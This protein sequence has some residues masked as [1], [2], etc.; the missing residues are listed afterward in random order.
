MIHPDGTN[1]YRLVGGAEYPS[2]SP[3]GKRIAY[4]D[5]ATRDLA[6]I[7]ADGTHKH[8]IA[9][10]DAYDG[11]PSFSPAGHRIAF[12]SQRGFKRVQERG[13]GPEFEIYSVGADGRRVRRLTR[14]HVEDRF[15]DYGPR[16][17]IVYSEGGRL[18]IVGRHG[19]HRHR[20]PL[21]GTFPDW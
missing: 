8:L 13:I 4:S 14:N 3:D 19:R 11:S 2:W 18:W 20:L 21:R 12:D 15:P 1:A 17:R 5:M 10:N 7:R 9:R 16:G 6:V